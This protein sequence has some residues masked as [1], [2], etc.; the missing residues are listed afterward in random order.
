MNARM[1][2]EQAVLH[3]RNIANEQV[4]RQCYFHE[5]VSDAAQD[6]LNSRE[7]K[8]TIAKLGITRFEG[9]K[10]LDLGAGNGIASY[11]FA[12]LGAKVTA[13]EPDKS[14]I[15][16]TGAIH[17]LNESLSPSSQIKTVSTFGEALPF[18]DSEFDVVYARQVL[19]HAHDLDK[20]VK[21]THRVLKP[22]GSLLTIRDHVVDNCSDLDVF[23][24]NHLLHKY[25]G[26]EHAFSLHE[27]REAFSKANMKIIEEIEPLASIINY[28]PST[29]Q[30]IAMRIRGLLKSHW[31]PIKYY[32]TKLLS[33]QKIVQKYG[34]EASKYLTDPGR[35]YSF[36]CSKPN[37]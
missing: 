26:G 19:H 2:W 4:V 10:V 11:A 18:P 24:E 34:R 36:I 31:N 37:S 13:V 33:P 28:F 32:Y 21:E 35:L 23:L 14:L 3:F 9:L 30:Q 25:Y 22:G 8:A 27:Y 20:L 1:T 12:K 7:F 15:V 17:Q 5:N 16:G 29:T 6:F